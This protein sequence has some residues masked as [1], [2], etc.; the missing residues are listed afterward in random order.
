MEKENKILEIL[1]LVQEKVLSPDEA[2][3]QILLLFSVSGRSE[4]SNCVHSYEH[5][6]TVK[7]LKYKCKCCGH[8]KWEQ[9]D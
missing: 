5:V 7:D 1:D 9:L 4:Q 2:L 6:L 3:P 8:E